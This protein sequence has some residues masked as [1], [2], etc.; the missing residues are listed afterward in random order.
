MA[1]HTTPEAQK[2]QAAPASAA[3]PIGVFD[4]GVG[5]LSVLQALRRQLP[6]ESLLYIAD[7]AHAPYGD[8]PTAYIETRALAL[9][10]HLQQAG[11]KAVVVACN[12][13]TVVAV[14]TLRQRYA[15]PIVALEPAIK[16][17]VAASRSGVVGVLA[18]SRTLE[19]AAV[20]RLRQ[21]HGGTT[22]VLGQACP[23]LV[24]QVERGE[25]DSP[26]TLA[27]LRSFIEPL[28]AQGADTLVLGCT[29]YPFL[30]TQ[31]QAVAGPGVLVLDSADAVAREVQRRLPTPPCMGPVPSAR[32]QDQATQASTRFFT[33]GNAD[34]ATAVFT[35]LW[36]T[37]VQVHTWQA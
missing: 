20:Q 24:E 34:A 23:G 31:I 12:T 27:L 14:H 28:L 1:R 9:T 32:P 11:A 5:G 21:R 19:S 37:P 26:A 33:T 35:R 29:H 18:T 8:R 36:G 3:A 4:S 25:L 2:A 15:L 17:A 7:S 22:R 30:R 6:Q 10:E 13:A 16:P